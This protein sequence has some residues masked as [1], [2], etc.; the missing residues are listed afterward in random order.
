V[1]FLEYNS[2]DVNNCFCKRV[3]NSRNVKSY[4]NN[5]CVWGSVFVGFLAY[6]ASG[7]ECN[8]SKFLVKYFSWTV[9]ANFITSKVILCGNAYARFCCKPLPCP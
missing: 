4:Q 7:Y 2:F 1:D 8:F 6:I 3:P 5:V 9:C